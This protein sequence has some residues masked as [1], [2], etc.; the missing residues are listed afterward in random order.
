MKLLTSSAARQW[1][2]R[3]CPQQK[4]A[5][6]SL[7]GI[8]HFEVHLQVNSSFKQQRYPGGLYLEPGWKHYQKAVPQSCPDSKKKTWLSLFLKVIPITATGFNLHSRNLTVLKAR[9]ACFGTLFVLRQKRVALL[10][11]DQ[12]CYQVWQVESPVT[13]FSLHEHSAFEVIR[14]STWQQLLCHPSVFVTKYIREITEGQGRVIM[15]HAL[16]APR[17]WSLGSIVM[18]LCWGRTSWKGTRVKTKQLTPCQS[19]NRDKG[20]GQGQHITLAV[21]TSH[22]FSLTGSFCE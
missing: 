8:L 9:E 20:R 13:L 5:L 17:M 14:Y 15:T 18:F 12:S 6:T 11:T 3:A 21:I 16:S 2:Q 1:I 22:L 10:N 7:S 19:R 4:R